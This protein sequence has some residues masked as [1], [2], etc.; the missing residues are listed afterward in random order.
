MMDQYLIRACASAQLGSIVDM[1]PKR[2]WISLSS[3]VVDLGSSA[4]AKL[5]SSYAESVVCQCKG[6]VDSGKPSMR[7]NG[8]EAFEEPLI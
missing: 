1:S 3:G 4:P 2:I 6:V 7:G 5:S 8:E